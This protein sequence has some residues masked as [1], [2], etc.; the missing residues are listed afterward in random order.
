MMEHGQVR[1]HIK[2]NGTAEL[3]KVEG[4][5]DKENISLVIDH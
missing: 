1:R 4:A 2:V 3:W 5:D